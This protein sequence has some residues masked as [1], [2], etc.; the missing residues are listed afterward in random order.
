MNDFDKKL[1]AMAKQEESSLQESAAQRIASTL[2]G[3]PEKRINLKRRPHINAWAVAVAAAIA[4]FLI[5]P[6]ISPSI[7]YAMQKL[8]IIGKVVKVVTIR[9]YKYE[10]SHHKANAAIPKVEVDGDSS[11]QQSADLINGDV[12]E[13]TSALLERFKHDTEELGNEAHTS[14]SIDYK[15][16]VNNDSWFTLKLT[17]YEGAGS[18]NTY[19]KYYHIDKTSGSI[20]TLKDL[21]NEN[22]GYKEAISENIKSQMK[23]QMASDNSIV[24][25][26]DSEIPEWDFTSIKIDQNFYFAEDGNI[27]I[28]FDKYEVGPGCM[29]CPEFEIPKEV[30]Q[31]YLKDK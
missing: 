8:P 26:L 1:K 21:F 13:L 2:E 24:Y 11:L 4:L 10:D 9:D 28:A 27:V 19:Y 7:A 12:E 15:V 17:V 3:L 16:L 20:V 22:S 23:V 14:L 6:N 29:G 18:S 30:Y 31:D 25:W 5:L